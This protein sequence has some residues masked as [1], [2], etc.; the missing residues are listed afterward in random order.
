MA[1]ILSNMKLGW[2]STNAAHFARIARLGLVLAAT[3]V[4]MATVWVGAYPA[5]SFQD[6]CTKIPIYKCSLH[7]CTSATSLALKRSNLWGTIPDNLASLTNLVYLDLS[8]NQ[9]SGSLPASVGSLV[10]N[11]R[12]VRISE[13]ELTGPLPPSFGSLAAVTDF[14]ITG[15][16]LA[17][18]IPNSFGSLDKARIV[19]LNNL[20]V[21]GTVPP[22]LSS[23]AAATQLSLQV[24]VS[25][26]V[27][28]AFF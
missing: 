6:G 5:C 15:L 17:S 10:E 23:L 25:F 2:H 8:E 26:C 12:T 9:L 21:S 24:C 28:C 1:K 3:W 14:E 13:N 7:L 4:S 27:L 19:R 20:G 18:S 22:V 11:L 16:S